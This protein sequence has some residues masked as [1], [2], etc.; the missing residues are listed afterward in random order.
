MWW[1]NTTQLKQCHL[2]LI[3]PWCSVGIKNS[4]L[5]LP[6]T[7]HVKG[8]KKGS[9][10]RSATEAIGQQGWAEQGRAHSYATLVFLARNIQQH[11]SPTHQLHAIACSTDASVWKAAAW[12][13]A[14]E[15]SQVKNDRAS[16]SPS[17]SLPGLEY[18]FTPG[19]V[20]YSF[21]MADTSEVAV[22]MQSDP[23]RRH[24]RVQRAFLGHLADR[25]SKECA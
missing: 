4:Q 13:R 8:G 3:H 9:F 11:R 6:W 24:H 7:P 21:L 12:R 10:W 20:S 19:A 18:C 14:R 15:S 5:Q 23:S 17:P 2:E 1:A 25:R 22:G 16:P